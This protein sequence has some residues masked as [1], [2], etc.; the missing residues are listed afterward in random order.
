MLVMAYRT[1][2][3]QLACYNMHQTMPGRC[4]PSSAQYTYVHR[5]GALHCGGKT[6]NTDDSDSED[7]PDTQRMPQ[8]ATS[9]AA[10]TL[11]TSWQ[12]QE[13]HYLSD[14]A[15]SYSMDKTEPFLQNHRV[16]PYSLDFGETG[17]LTQHADLMVSPH[18]NSTGSADEP[19]FYSCAPST[20]STAPAE[21]AIHDRLE[22]YHSGALQTDEAVNRVM[23]L[24]NTARMWD[25]T[26]RRPY[27]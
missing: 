4:L 9:A 5:V 20:I 10:A 1:T 6:A 16:G 17:S 23:W 12:N 15:S 11:T 26:Q 24:L 8:L 21:G 3:L 7:V 2:P 25:H 27:L 22:D 13:R 14:A 19:S 18:S